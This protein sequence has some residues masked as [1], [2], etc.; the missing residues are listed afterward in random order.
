MIE[1]D[2]V[3]LKERVWR[4]FFPQEPKVPNLMFH[5]H[6][7]SSFQIDPHLLP[8]EKISQIN[9]A[10]RKASI[11]SSVNDLNRELSHDEIDRVVFGRVGRFIDNYVRT[12]ALCEGGYHPTVVS[13]GDSGIYNALVVAEA[14]SLESVLDLIAKESRVLAI[15]RG[16]NKFANPEIPLHTPQIEPDLRDFYDVLAGTD[17]NDPKI[18][19]VGGRGNIMTKAAEI[20]QE[21]IRQTIEPSSEKEVRIAMKSLRIRK[22]HEIG[23][24]D[25]GDDDNYLTI[26]AAALERTDVR[27]GIATGAVA[28]AIL[29]FYVHKK[30]RQKPKKV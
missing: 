27:L 7:D 18:P 13:S 19:V 1:K 17:I 9:N 11:C 6:S 2:G 10:L 30:R 14:I 16:E 4:L 15:A 20:R 21:L 5:I 25:A 22:P 26:A 12:Q 3:D 29:G 28:A 23:L 24:D 8:E